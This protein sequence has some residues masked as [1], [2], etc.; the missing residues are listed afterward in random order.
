MDPTK[1]VR[2][3]QRCLLTE[4]EDGTGVLLHLDTKFYFTLNDTGVFVWKQLVRDASS[5]PELAEQLSER[6][7]VNVE[8]AFRDVI[9][10]LVELEAN[11][12]IHAA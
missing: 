6:F 12:L 1:K 3:N 9:S 11:Q 4:L 10:L 7:E 2:S 8:Q 5:G